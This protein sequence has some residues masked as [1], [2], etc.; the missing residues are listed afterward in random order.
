MIIYCVEDDMNVRDLVVYA[1]NTGGFRATGFPDA[2]SFLHGLSKELPVLV[3]LDIMLPG[4][5]GLT[6]L[7]D[8]KSNPETRDIP[9]I[10]LTAKGT[11]FDKVQGLDL[12][13]DDYITKPFGV[14]ELISRIKS[15]LR[16]VTPK[17]NLKEISVGSITLN[18]A[19][20][21]VLAENQEVRLTLKE[22]ELLQYLMENKGIVLSRE[23]LLDRIWGY[24][25]EGETRTVDVH[26]R[27][28]RR[29]LGHCG[30]EIETVRGIGY[31]T[32]GS[33]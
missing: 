27:T 24:D 20:H 9:V 18:P 26:I 15:V 33:G 7:K 29:K 30:E 1:L 25:F 28:L 4:T 5:D 19:K 13:A 32:G 31:R 3:L 17:E 2:K 11:E 22:F 12:G 21:L 23:K 6:V 10:M 16:R 14:L 8:L